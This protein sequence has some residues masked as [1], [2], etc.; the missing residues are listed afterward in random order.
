VPIRG[1]GVRPQLERPFPQ[2]C[3]LCKACLRSQV[4]AMSRCAQHTVKRGGD[5][6][7]TSPA[8]VIRA[9]SQRVRPTLQ[10]R[11]ALATSHC[12]ASL[13]GRVV[14]ER[15]H[16][17]CQPRNF[18]VGQPLPR[19]HDQ[20]SKETGEQRIGVSSPVFPSRSDNST[21]C[22]AALREDPAPSR[23]AFNASIATMWISRRS[24]RRGN[25]S[26]TTTDPM[27]SIAE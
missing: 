19:G 18:A 15:E 9:K 3:R 27:E 2:K 17:S 24:S 8:P 7:P 16:V 5:S 21:I 6:L 20:P 22:Q 14:A 12:E 11:A 26:T 1:R 10:R 4:A 23:D 25:A 13:R